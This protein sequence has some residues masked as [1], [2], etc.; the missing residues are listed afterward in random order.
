VAET[1]EKYPGHGQTIEGVRMTVTDRAGLDSPE[2]GIE[3]LSALHHLYPTQFKL[4]KA[5]ALVANSETMAAL[6]RG[7]DPGTIAAGWAAALAEFKA[8]RQ[9]YLLYP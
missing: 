6:G 7:D 9:K 4:E 5:T 1:S 3:V 2:M 8:R